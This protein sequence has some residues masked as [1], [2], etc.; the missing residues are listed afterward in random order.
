MTADGSGNI[1]HRISQD[2]GTA[3]LDHYLSFAADLVDFLAAAFSVAKLLRFGIE[4]ITEPPG[5]VTRIISAAILPMPGQ[6]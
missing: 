2:I 1:A 5:R 3:Q 4:M 6:S